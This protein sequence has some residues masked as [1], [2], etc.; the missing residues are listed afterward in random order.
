MKAE[1]FTLNIPCQPIERGEIKQGM[2]V[3]YRLG[4]ESDFLYGP[5]E[6]RRID[7]ALTLTGLNG[8]S[9]PLSSPHPNPDL[10]FYRAVNRCRY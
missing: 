7:G 10:H 5:F 3:H 8:I 6:V 1:I 2:I 4:S 9:F